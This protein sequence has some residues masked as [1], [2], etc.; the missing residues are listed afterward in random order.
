MEPE[1]YFGEMMLAAYEP[2]M[3]FFKGVRQYEGKIWFSVI[4]DE[5]QP[6][7][8]N[9]RFAQATA[10]YFGEIIEGECEGTKLTSG[11]IGKRVRIQRRIV[12][13]EPVWMV[14]EILF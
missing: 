9:R 1:I 11:C 5:F 12:L 4:I 8:G 14:V 10:K 6:A 3:D 7:G 2:D 13:E